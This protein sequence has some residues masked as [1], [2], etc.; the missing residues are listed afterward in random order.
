MSKYS[1]FA[2]V[3]ATIF[4]LI[5]TAKADKVWLNHFGARIQSLEPVW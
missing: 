4:W 2:I 1:D 5:G 3:V